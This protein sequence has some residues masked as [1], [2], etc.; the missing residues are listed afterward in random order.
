MKSGIHPAYKE[1]SI[2]ISNDVFKTMSTHHAA[3]IL[4]DVDFRKH[5]AWNKESGN[6]VNQSNKSVSDFNKRFSG[7]SFVSK[8]SVKKEQ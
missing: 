5:P 3:E 8:A 6:I 4:M 1:L 7:L 2:K